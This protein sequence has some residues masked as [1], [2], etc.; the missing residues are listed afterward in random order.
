[1]IED[2]IFYFKRIEQLQREYYSLR[3][4]REFRIGIKWVNLFDA[5]R[6]RCLMKHLKKELTHRRN[7]RYTKPRSKCDFAYGGYPNPSVR[8]AVYSCI[9]GGYDNLVEPF[10]AINNVDYIMFTDNPNLKGD[11]W[12]VRPIPSTIAEHDDNTLINRYIK[13]H[14]DVV[15]T[16]Y[17]YALYVDGNIC[18]VSNVRNMVNAIMPKTGIALHRHSS[19]DCIYNEVK[20]CLNTKRGNAHKLKEQVDRY[21]N[22]GMPEHYGLLEAT[23]ILTD[24]HNSIA[25]ELQDKWWQEFLVSESRRDQISLPYI[26]WKNNIDIE[27]VGDLGCPVQQNPK[28]RKYNHNE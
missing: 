7:A 13:M 12:Q 28:F 16:Q 1:M 18:V 19:R 21:K 8:I 22:E 4:T 23:V 11:K 6:Q 25:L 10:F 24:L 26:L 20:V 9:T 14:P 2:D 5:I 3:Q 27:D 17:D 15:G